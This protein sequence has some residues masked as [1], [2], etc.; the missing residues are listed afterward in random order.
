M[1]AL[2]IRPNIFIRLWTGYLTALR[3]RPIRTKM[4]SSSML[5]LIG[6]S[7]AQLGIERKKVRFRVG[8]TRDRDQDRWD[9]C[10]GYLL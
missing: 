4:A 10:L 1:S 6:D 7:V 3:E 2:A 8:G 5:Y 9:V